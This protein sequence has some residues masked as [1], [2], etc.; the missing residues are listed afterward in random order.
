M[1]TFSFKLDQEKINTLKQTFKEYIKP[2]KNEY[3]DTFIQKDDLTISIYTSDKV[4]FQGND[5]FFYAQAYLN[6]KKTRQAGSDE[7]G[8]GDV[9][10]PVVV[11]SAIIEIQDYDFIE[12]KG[13]TDSKQLTD[14]YIMSL[15][16]ILIEKFKHSLLILDNETYNKVHETNNLNAIKAKMHNQAYINLINKGY[17]MPKACYVDQFC[18]EDNYYDYLKDEKDIYHNLVFETKAESSYPAVAVASVIARYA[19]LKHM[20]KMNETYHMVFHKGAGEEVDK[21]IEEFVNKYGKDK[22]NKVAK[23]HFKNLDKYRI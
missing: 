14:S 9:F 21:V 8:T 23:L 16:P 17:D 12:E 2:N 5:A 7:V 10:G 3:I 1:G 19:F 15:G 20:D 6:T 13:I 4:V 11:C 18:Q 22:L